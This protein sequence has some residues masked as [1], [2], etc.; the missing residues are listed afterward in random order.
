M[1][2]RSF[3]SHFLSPS[4]TFPNFRFFKMLVEVTEGKLKGERLK[5]ILTSEEYYSFKGIPFAKPPVGP[6]RFKDPEP[7]EKYNDVWDA[8]QE[9]LPCI[10]KSFAYSGIGGDEDC[11]YLNVY[12]PK[13]PEKGDAL[14]PVMFYLF[15]GGYTEGQKDAFLYGPDFL[16]AKDVVLVIPNYRLH[17]F[18]FLNLG[19]PECSGNQGLKDQLAALKWT[20]ANISKFG[21]DPNNITIFGESAGACSVQFLLYSPLLKGKGLFHKAIAQSGSIMLHNRS[22][23]TVDSSTKRATRV[24]K[25]L[26]FESEDPRELHKFL[27]SAPA[28]DLTLNTIGILTQKE[29]EDGDLFPFTPTVDVVG[30]ANER[31]ITARGSEI[32]QQDPQVPVMVGLCD[33]EAI[34]S[35]KQLITEKAPGEQFISRA[36][37]VIIP[38]LFKGIPLDEETKKDIV[39]KFHQFYFEGKSTYED[40]I[41]AS[42]D[43][44]SDIMYNKG[45]YD[46]IFANLKYSS[47]PTYSYLF[48]YRGTI[49]FLEHMFNYQRPSFLKGAGHTD[50][51]GYLLYQVLKKDKNPLESE[52][53]RKVISHMSTIWSNFAKF[54]DPGKNLPIDFKPVTTSNKSYLDINEE[55]TIKPGIIFEERM[56]FINEVYSSVT[57]KPACCIQKK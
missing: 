34:I 27:M 39:N 49:G 10:Q 46:Y 37:S 19:I 15:G 55:L 18:G 16:V 56:K 42:I 12:S 23:G 44:Y 26:G 43:L 17:I 3:S 41:I 7:P 2:L 38:I 50:E 6:L 14:K 21:G 45:L 57:A 53:D 52:T 1:I 8:T 54:S 47:Q 13:L 32:T 29:R 35:L 48:T 28:R 51:L 24:A 30:E 9:R 36:E 40:I 5:N 4:K 22:F 11:L 25:K 31:M 33:Q 20:K